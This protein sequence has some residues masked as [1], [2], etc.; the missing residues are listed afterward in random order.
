M[1]DSMASGI[2]IGPVSI[3]ERLL[4][5]SF[6]ATAVSE[7]RK[8]SRTPDVTVITQVLQKEVEKRP[9]M[10][11]ITHCAVIQRALRDMP[12]IKEAVRTHLVDATEVE[13]TNPDK[14]YAA[15]LSQNSK[16][17]S[18]VERSMANKQPGAAG[19][20]SFTRK[21]RFDNPNQ[22]S[23]SKAAKPPGS[24]ASAVFNP[25]AQFAKKLNM[26]KETPPNKDYLP[27]VK[28][29]TRELRRS[30]STEKK[31]WNCKKPGHSIT[32]CPDAHSKFL[33][34]EFCWYP[35]QK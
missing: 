26:L 35:K 20:S 8:T 4:S 3:M 12:E 18:H 24:N 21:R 5:F 32:H 28:G 9:Q 19:P 2:A 33:S 15:L 10:D 14:M 22:A 13:Q 7:A 16:F 31:C 11:P 23:G 30:L 6:L 27:W 29:L 1:V 17:R 34:K 25:F